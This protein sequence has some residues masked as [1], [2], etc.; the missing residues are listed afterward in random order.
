MKPIIFSGLEHCLNNKRASCELA[1]DAL[2]EIGA[3]SIPLVISSS[4]S[5]E[6][7]IELVQEF[8][9][10]PYLIG[11]NG[12]SFAV[13]MDSMLN[14][15]F[16]WN[17][18]MGAYN[19]SYD[20]DSMSRILAVLE[21]ARSQI[22]DCFIEF[23]KIN[24]NHSNRLADLNYNDLK[25]SLNRDVNEVLIWQGND[26]QW[27]QFVNFIEEKSLRVQNSEFFIQV[28]DPK[29]T[30]K[31]AMFAF[32]NL[33][34][35]TFPEIPWYSV[36]FGSLEEDVSMLEHVDYPVVVRRPKLKELWLERQDYQL[37]HLFTSEG[38]NESLFQF[39]NLNLQKL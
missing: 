14:K 29:H 24:S 3:R 32:L 13:P 34:Q 1:H 28:M 11:E 6:E 8:P 16:S 20:P 30:K 26:Y 36:G 31:T 21:E 12:A 7:L 2:Y 4:K 15:H 35:K 27:W 19:V 25:R 5:L 22:G 38:W 23:S 37:T 39:L 18:T 9:V 17:H 10:I 33:F